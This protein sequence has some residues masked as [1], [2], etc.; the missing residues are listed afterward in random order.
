FWHQ[1]FIKIDLCK[2]EIKENGSRILA[3]NYQK[4]SLVLR[5]ITSEICISLNNAIEEVVIPLD[6]IMKFRVSN[7]RDI[8]VEFKK[9]FEKF[10]FRYQ[11]GPLNQREQISLDPSRGKLDGAQ[12]ILFVPA[13]WVD[14]NTLIFFGEGIKRLRFDPQNKIKELGINNNFSQNEN[15]SYRAPNEKELHVTCSFLTKTYALQ[16]PDDITFEEILNNV[17]T[18]YKVEVNPNRVTYKNQVNEIITLIDEED[19]EAA[20][21]EAKKAKSYYIYMYF[22]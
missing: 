11:Q 15:D 12:T 1:Q 22:S 14:N 3:A 9:N 6:Q 4:L 13:E 2:L 8:T 17:Q 5:F 20:K 18:R 19:W 21:W 16:V 10:Y 7:D